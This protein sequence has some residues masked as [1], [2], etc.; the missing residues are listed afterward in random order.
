M[1]DS[2]KMNVMF[3]ANDVGTALEAAWS[4]GLLCG[5][6]MQKVATQVAMSQ[7]DFCPTCQVAVT[8]RLMATV[9]RRMRAELLRRGL[10]PESAQIE[11]D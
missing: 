9:E 2:Y 11:S 10:P 1:K 5:T 7:S 3:G 8:A 6:C 4:E